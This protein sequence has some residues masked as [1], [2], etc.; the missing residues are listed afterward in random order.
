MV[1]ASNLSVRCCQRS[2]PLV[3]GQTSLDPDAHH[4]SLVLDLVFGS[5][6][7]KLIKWWICQI[8]GGQIFV[9]VSLIILNETKTFLKKTKQRSR[10]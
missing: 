2:N 7:A 4:V 1:H 8:G 5:G 6:S 9:L 10:G 3:A